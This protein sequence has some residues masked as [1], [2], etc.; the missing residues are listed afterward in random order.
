MNKIGT[1]K[2]RAGRRSVPI[3]P[4]LVGILRRYFAAH[5]VGQLD[6]AFANGAG[7]VESLANIYNRHWVPFCSEIGLVHSEGKRKGGPLY[8]IHALRHACASLWIEQRVKPKKIQ[9][10]MGHS[11][12]KIT[13]DL[14]GHLFPDDE[15][16]ATTT[17][18]V[19]RE[20][21]Q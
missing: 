16:D 20:L 10:W 3:G 8:K 4:L 11:S 14:Y 18:A 12:I 19:E 9:A 13:M 7:N 17:A 2:T 5:A 1:V 21:V 6:L 15:D